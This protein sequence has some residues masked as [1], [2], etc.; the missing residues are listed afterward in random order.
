MA[1][2]QPAGGLPSITPTIAVPYDVLQA[3]ADSQTL[4]ASGYAGNVNTQVHIGPGRFDGLLALNLSNAK[5]STGD[6]KYAFYLL[7]S[8]DPAFGNG[9]N[10]ILVTHDIAATAALRL[11]ATICAVSPAVPPPGLSASRIVEAV[12]EHNVSEH[13]FEYQQLYVLIAGTTPTVTFSAWLS[14]DTLG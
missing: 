2:T 3:F 11:L 12:A 9:N 6:E 10:E 13:T 4:V 7:G 14:Y 1:L 5:V 8:N